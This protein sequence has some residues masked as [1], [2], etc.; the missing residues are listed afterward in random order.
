MSRHFNVSNIFSL[1]SEDIRGHLR[2][3]TVSTRLFFIGFARTMAGEGRFL[4]ENLRILFVIILLLL[5]L[6]SVEL[7]IRV[8]VD[9]CCLGTN[10][11]IVWISLV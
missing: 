4:I 2:A 6:V 7:P 11:S 9:L 10:L 8:S 3:R 5:I 1:L